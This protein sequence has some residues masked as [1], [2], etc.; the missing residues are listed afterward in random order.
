MPADLCSL[1]LDV[2][3]NIVLSLDLESVVSLSRVSPQLH[4]LFQEESICRKIVKVSLVAADPNITST[5]AHADLCKVYN[6][7]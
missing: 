4:S 7:G 5:D 3:F 1:P 2:F 6:G